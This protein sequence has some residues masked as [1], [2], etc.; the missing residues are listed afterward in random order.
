MAL[1]YIAPPSL[2]LEQG[3]VAD[4][5]NSRIPRSLSICEG[6]KDTEKNTES[7]PKR[8]FRLPLLGPYILTIPLLPGREFAFPGN[9][10][11]F[12]GITSD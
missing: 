7:S 5:S 3:G 2:N 8:L 11:M 6:A 9:F 10:L 4:R 12:S 1:W